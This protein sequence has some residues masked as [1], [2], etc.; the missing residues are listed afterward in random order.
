M[1]GY[2]QV[3]VVG[4][5]GNLEDMK[6]LSSGRAVLNFSVAVNKSWTDKATN[7]KRESVTWFRVAAFGPLAEVCSTYLSKGQQVTVVGEVATRAYID[8]S[9]EA[10]AS[11]DV[12]ARD[13][14]FGG[15]SDNDAS[16]EQR[17]PAES[18]DLPF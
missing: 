7:E 14:V 1:A 4:N 3:I 17:G 18:G 6:Y 10:A 2:Q 8:K 9:G 5:I 15:R 16:Q 12:T 13:V 11:L